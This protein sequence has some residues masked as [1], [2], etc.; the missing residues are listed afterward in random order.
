MLPSVKEPTEIPIQAPAAVVNHNGTVAKGLAGLGA[1]SSLLRS[2][3]GQTAE[4][5]KSDIIP[6]TGIKASALQIEEALKAY[7]QEVS[8]GILA[9]TFEAKERVK[10][11]EGILI[12]EVPSETVASRIRSKS[13]EITRFIAN[14]TKT[15]AIIIEVSVSEMVIESKVPYTDNERL[16]YFINKNPYLETFIQQLQLVPDRR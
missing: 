1:K 3:L 4:S 15:D 16:Q 6:S 2:A 10:Y 12:L 5:T 14:K 11:Q 9:S 8:D 13:Q 7:F